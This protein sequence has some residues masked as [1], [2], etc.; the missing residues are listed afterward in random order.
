[1]KYINTYTYIGNALYGLQGMK[2]DSVEVCEMLSALVPKIYRY[3]CIYVSVCICTYLFVCEV[4]EMLSA[5]VPRIY[6]YINTYM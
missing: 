4:C 6:S 1:L 5:L 3:I 2:S